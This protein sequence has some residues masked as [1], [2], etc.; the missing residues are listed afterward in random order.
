MKRLFPILIPGLVAVLAVAA[1][2]AWV[3][4]NRFDRLTPRLPVADETDVVAEVGKGTLVLGPGVV[5]ANPVPLPEWPRFRGANYDGI[6]PAPGSSGSPA[7]LART[8]PAGG[9]KVLWE[10]DLG[11]GYAGPAIWNGRIYIFDYDM[12]ALADTIRC[13]SLTD[14]KEIWRYSYPMKIQRNH[15]MSRTIPTVTPGGLVGIG[16]KCHV[17]CLDPVTGE[18]HWA[19]DMVRQYGTKVPRWY[20]GQCPIV[21]GDRVIFAPGGAKALLVALDL[22]TGKELW[23]TPNARGWQQTHSSPAP[24]EIG[25]QRMIVYCGSGGVVAVAPDDGRVLWEFTGWQVSFANVPAPVPVGEGRLFLSGG[26]EAGCMLL[27][28][29]RAG[30]KWTATPLWRREQAVFGATQHTPIFYQGHLYGMRP[31]TDNQFACIDL[32]GSLKWES[33][34]KNV[35]K[36]GMAPYLL[37]GGLL[38]IMDDHGKLTLA[39]ATPEAYKPLATAQVL[40]G[41][42]VWAPMA[43]SGTHLLVRDLTKM[44]CLDMGE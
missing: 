20:A 41:I 8:F 30:D 28:V 34:A 43:I 13:L 32:T 31:D 35:F 29:A 7:K 3:F 36:R 44:V 4:G 11:E 16:P 40:H 38:Y 5:A 15:G 9:P 21:E 10:V 42:D 19:V 23:R 33:G 26:Y 25:G 2:S 24:V 1:L 17:T 12:Q 18:F 37:A 14:G 22:K 6:A 27:Q 39:E